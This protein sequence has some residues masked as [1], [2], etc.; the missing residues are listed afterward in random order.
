[1]AA[2]P[3]R[4]AYAERIK[5]GD[6]F[7]TPDRVEYDLDASATTC[8]VHLAP[9]ER[10]MR[11]AGVRVRLSG[12]GRADA[13]AVTEEGAVRAML[14]LPASVVYEELSAYD[15]SAEDPP[16][17]RWRCD[18]CNT[19]IWVVHPRVGAR[20]AVAFPPAGAR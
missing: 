5:A 19:L 8:C 10:A 20:D 7:W 6:T 14:S 1:M 3:R 16:V 2:D 9:L 18:P 11:A 15:R 12:A 13:L 17:A 4:R